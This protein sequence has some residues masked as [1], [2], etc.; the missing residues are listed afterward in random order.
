M[1][2]PSW[3]DLFETYPLSFFL[4]LFIVVGMLY[5]MLLWFIWAIVETKF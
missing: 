4:V 3:I 1:K 5:A 2:I